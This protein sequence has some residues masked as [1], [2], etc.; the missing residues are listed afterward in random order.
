MDTIP[1]VDPVLR[2]FRAVLSEIYGRQLERVVLFGSRARGD[3]RP[4]S[5]YDFG[6]IPDRAAR[7]M[8]AT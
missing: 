2:R 6:N 3:A 8:T 1:Q 5:D 4:D 7:P